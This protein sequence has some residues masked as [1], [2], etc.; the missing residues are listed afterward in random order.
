MAGKKRK[1]HF[2]VAIEAGGNCGHHTPPFHDQLLNAGSGSDVPGSSRIA[3][4]IRVSTRTGKTGGRTDSGCQPSKNSNAGPHTR[5]WQGPMPQRVS[6]LA[7]RQEECSRRRESDVLATAN[8]GLGVGQF[9]Q[10]GTEGKG[11][12]QSGSGAAQPVAPGEQRAGGIEAAGG[13]IPGNLP[14]EQRQLQ[15]ADAGG[16][17]GTVNAGHCSLLKIIYTDCAMFYGAAQE[18]GQLGVGHEMKAAGQVVAGQAPGFGAA[19]QGDAFQF[20]FAISG[21]RPATCEIRGTGELTAE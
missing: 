5:P 13:G 7:A 8:Q 19:A 10:L 6:S 15:A 3:A 12:L 4:A 17:A 18:R 16:L 1:I 11:S 21:N 14:F 2:E 9:F 20:F